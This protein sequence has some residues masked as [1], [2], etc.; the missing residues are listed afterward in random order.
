MS[1][2]LADRFFTTKVTWEALSFISKSEVFF[3]HQQ[4]WDLES[5]M[6]PEKKKNVTF[7]YNIVSFRLRESFYLT[8]NLKFLLFPTSLDLQTLIQL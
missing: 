8:P 1:P 7:S 6:D 2:A 4:E 5:N 3:I